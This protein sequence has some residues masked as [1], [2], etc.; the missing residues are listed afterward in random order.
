MLQVNFQL[1]KIRFFFFRIL[2]KLLIPFFVKNKK[3]NLL[4]FLFKLNLTKIKKIL[5]KNSPKYK[6]VVLSKTGGVDDLIESQKNNN[7][8][9]LYLDCPRIFFK[10]LYKANLNGE[11]KEFIDNER[12]DQSRKANN[13]VNDKKVEKFRRKNKKFLI[14]FINLLKKKYN[15]D[16]FLGFN[17]DYYAEKSLQDACRELKIPFLLLFKESVKTESQQKLQTYILKKKKEKFN[18]YKVAVYSKQAKNFLT[19]SGICKN[20]RIDVVG[21]SRLSICFSYKKVMPKNQILYYAIEKNRGL[22]NTIF[23]TYGKKNFSDL[24]EFKFYDRKFNWKAL[25]KKTLKILKKFAINNPNIPIIIKSKIGDK[26]DKNEYRNLPKNIRLIT[27]GTGQIFLKNSK[28]VIGWN[29]TAIMEAIAANRFLL[30]PYFFKKDNVS[31]KNE[32]KLKLKKNNYGFSES[33]F[34]KK[35]NFFVKKKYK[36]KKI[37]NNLYSLEYYL[38]NSDNNAGKR[39]NNFLKSN[40]IYN[41]F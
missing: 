12:L 15:F 33:D 31:K 2:N 30:L 7:K 19:S 4:C 16:A 9:I 6:V 21:C 27:S 10:I 17:Y 11:Y 28:V 32:L 1:Y 35:L 25:H 40:L 3:L 41:S 38:G 34:Y 36:E 13:Y 20:K 22:P 18:F 29:T 26:L 23:K 24:K 39:L 5:P 37:Y 8:D 14:N